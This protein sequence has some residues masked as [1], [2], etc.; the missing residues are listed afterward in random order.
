MLLE[1]ILIL[2][3]ALGAS[4]ENVE[5]QFERALSAYN[6]G[7]LQIAKDQLEAICEDY[8]A[9]PG[10]R[11]LL[12]KIYVIRKEKPEEAVRIY[13]ALSKENPTDCDIWAELADAR[14]LSA[15]AFVA[16]KRHTAPPLSAEEIRSLLSPAIEDEEKA[17]RLCP[18]NQL[19]VRR[20]AELCYSAGRYSEAAEH[21]QRA[22][23]MKPDDYKSL[24][25][26]ARSQKFS[27]NL[28]GAAETYRQLIGI[29]PT[30]VTFR[31]EYANVLYRLGSTNE[32]DLQ[33]REHRRL[34]PLTADAIKLREEHF[35]SMR[36]LGGR[37][38]VFEGWESYSHFMKQRDYKNAMKAAEDVRDRLVAAVREPASRDAAQGLLVR[39]EALLKSAKEKAETR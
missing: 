10:A 27:N 14:E 4:P 9:F 12:A 25:A 20:L 38:R 21:F 33:L 11:R 26:L 32:A 13:D 7:N 19:A 31:A 3:M 2:G 28:Q 17:L 35:S 30:N 8:P 34:D 5:A 37:L 22:T 36:E 29:E 16:S 23:L 18:N 15:H 24:A 1:G 39:T 6:E